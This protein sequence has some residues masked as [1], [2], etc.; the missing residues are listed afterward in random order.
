[1]VGALKCV[2]ITSAVVA[3]ASFTN[4]GS[5]AKD[6]KKSKSNWKKEK[7]VDKTPIPCYNTDTKKRKEM[8]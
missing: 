7:G 3:L 2:A 6:T 5:K 4:R 8:K 1:M